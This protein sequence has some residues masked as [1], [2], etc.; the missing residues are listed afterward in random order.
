M[1]KITKEQG[2]KFLNEMQQPI[3][4]KEQ[5]F[6]AL[7]EACGTGDAVNTKH[8]FFQEVIIKFNASK[9]MAVIANR[10]PYETESHYVDVAIFAYI[11]AGF[12]MKDFDKDL[13]TYKEKY[14]FMCTRAAKCVTTFASAQKRIPA[15][16][17][18]LGGDLIFI[19]CL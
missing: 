19:D 16:Q 17:L 13:K 12:N 4:S 9:A 1:M 14:S 3:S 2:M 18:L 8:I 10:M 7:F 6:D 11:K 5:I 15:V